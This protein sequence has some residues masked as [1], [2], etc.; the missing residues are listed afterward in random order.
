MTSHE[1][2]GSPMPWSKTMMRSTHDDRPGACHYVTNQSARRGTIFFD[3]RCYH[4][5]LNLVAKLPDLYGLRIHGYAI[6]PERYELMIESMSGNLAK[7]MIYLGG[8]YARGLNRMQ[9]WTGPVFRHGL[10]SREIT[11]PDCW[12]HLLTHVH[13]TPVRAGLARQAAYARWTSHRAYVGLDPTPDWLTTQPL[14]DTFR[15]MAAYR[16]YIKEVHTGQRPAPPGFDERTSPDPDISATRPPLPNAQTRPYLSADEALTM[17]RELT[18]A[19]L[20][21]LT[22]GRRGR[23]GN[24]PRRLAIWWLCRAT[25]LSQSEVGRMLG[26]TP[27]SVSRT[28]AQLQSRRCENQELRDWTDRLERWF[29]RTDRSGKVG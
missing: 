2:S 29:E 14:I 9:A 12:K 6:L 24:R 28:R 22:H 15:S 3:Q 18:G 10:Q 1:P 16:R 25:D 23:G 13:L 7:G 27:D 19:A 4:L 8:R 5:F 26:A 21:D 20:E 17:I 11:D